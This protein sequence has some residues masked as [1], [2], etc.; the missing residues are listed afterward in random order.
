MNPDALCEFFTHLTCG[1]GKHK[2]KKQIKNVQFLIYL[3]FKKAA[4]NNM[5]GITW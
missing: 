1:P 4:K 5:I 2:G 3:E